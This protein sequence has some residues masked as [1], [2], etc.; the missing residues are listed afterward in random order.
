MT[1]EYEVLYLK[2]YFCDR[3]TSIRLMLTY[4]G[5][6]FKDSTFDRKSEWPLVKDSLPFGQGPVLIID[7]KIKIS[8]TIAILQ[9]IA[10]EHGLEPKGTMNQAFAEMFAS[11]C[12][13]TISAIQPWVRAIIYEKT[14][15]TIAL[16][17]FRD[18]FAKFFDEQLKK[19]GS[20][21][22]IGDTITWVDFMAANLSEMMQFLGDSAVLDDYP[23]L[24]L[25]WKS[26]YTHPKLIAAVEK[27]R[28]KKFE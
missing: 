2:F 11:Q 20:G 12:H 24:K 16:P 26:I 15:K 22:L 13:D 19:N 6:P 9:Y 10:K 18:M 5:I 27:Q 21:Y 3:A 4:L 1:P 23:N 8:Q 14:W 25:H 7:K 17:K 28:S